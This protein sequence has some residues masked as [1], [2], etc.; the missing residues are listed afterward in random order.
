MSIKGR[1]NCCC[2]CLQFPVAFAPVLLLQWG[3][4]VVIHVRARSLK[5][6]RGFIVYDWIGDH[7]NNIRAV[8]GC[9]VWA[10]T[11]G[12]ACL[13]F[14]IRDKSKQTL[15]PV[16]KCLVPPRKRCYSVRNLSPFKALRVFTLIFNKGEFV[17]RYLYSRFYFLAK[18]GFALIIP[19]KNPCP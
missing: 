18:L 9:A 6:A 1:R 15:L 5:S 12:D 2:C 8:V 3:K 4:M 16:E 14:T 11:I 19:E 10:F 17:R 7:L 13:S